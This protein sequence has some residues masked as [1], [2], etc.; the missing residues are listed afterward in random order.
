[1]PDHPLAGIGTISTVPVYPY[2]AASLIGLVV[3]VFYELF[4]V[5][6]DSKL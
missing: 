1:M 5:C 3:Y 2:A 4:R 6:F